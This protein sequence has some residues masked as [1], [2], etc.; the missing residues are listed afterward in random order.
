[1]WTYNYIKN[2]IKLNNIKQ[3]G[4]L[5][6][7]NL[8]GQNYG[9]SILEK[10]SLIKDMY[11]VCIPSGKYTTY[12]GDINTYIDCLIRILNNILID[13]K[14]RDKKVILMSH[15]S[16]NMSGNISDTDIIEMLL[17]RLDEISK[18]RIIAITDPVQPL[19]AR[20]ILGNSMFSITG[21]MHGA[22]STF[23]MKKPAIA[24]SYSVKYRGV[25]G[26]ELQ[27]NDLIIEAANHLMWQRGE[28]VKLVKEKID[29]LVSNYELITNDILTIIEKIKK[30]ALSQIHETV[31]IVEGGHERVRKN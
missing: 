24:L 29:Y 11:I 3:A 7:L 1:L 13:K 31:E 8:P 5:A 15:V 22:I 25:I 19:I 9:W 12:S 27:R 30:T 6:F 21:R 16:K 17:A 10:Y 18:K 14:F 20:Y 26:D 28:I 2:V 4:D 23:Q